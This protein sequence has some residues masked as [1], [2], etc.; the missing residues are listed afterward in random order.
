MRPS[1]RV[2][3]VY[4]VDDEPAVLKALSRLLRSAGFEAVG[5]GS[6]E[7]FLVRVDP[8]SEGCIVLDVSMPGLDGLA[9]QEALAARGIELPTL[10][11]TGHGDI[12]QSVRAMKGGAVDFLMK[13]VDDG[14]FLRAV[15]EALERGRAGRAGREEAVRLRKRLATLSPREREVL[16]GVVAGRLNKQIAGELG[17]A[18]K[19]V[20]VHRGRVM[21]KM[22]AA[23]VAELVRMADR[24]GLRERP[25]T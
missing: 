20:K 11:L 16:A 8:E 17:I 3:R 5:F 10:F 18:E 2:E 4:L 23:S 6:A 14:V 22:Q 12:P 19:T 1:V 21:E 15:R 7:E 24:A 9:L 25:G 13:P